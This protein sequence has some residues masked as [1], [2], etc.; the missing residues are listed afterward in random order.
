MSKSLLIHLSS[1]IYPLF[2]RGGLGDY[3]HSLTNALSDDFDNEIFIPYSVDFL[4]HNDVAPFISFANKTVIDFMGV[5]DEVVFFQYTHPDLKQKVHI[6]KSTNF[7]FDDITKDAY[8]INN[9]IVLYLHFAKAVLSQVKHL[10]RNKSRMLLVLHDWQSF[11]C[12]F[13]P[14][15]IIELDIKTVAIIHN[16]EYQGEM[17]PPELRHLR[18]EVSLEIN[19]YQYAEKPFSLTTL[20]LEKSDYVL[21]VSPN[22]AYEITNFKIPHPSL[23]EA[24]QRGSIQGFINGV[25]CQLWSSETDPYL[26]RNFTMEDLNVKNELKRDLLRKYFKSS[27]ES[28]I[29]FS[30]IS[31]FCSQKGIDL[32]FEDDLR[33]FHYLEETKS[34]M[35][36]YSVIDASIKNYVKEAIAKAR[37]ITNRFHFIDSYT[38]SGAHNLFA[39][40]D[41]LIMPSA[42]EP[43]GLSQLYAMQYGT[44]PIVS[45]RGGLRDTVEQG[46]TGFVMESYSLLAMLKSLDEAQNIFK[47]DKQSW[48][49]LIVNAKN[50][51]K[52]WE[53]R[54][55]PYVNFFN[56]AIADS[57]K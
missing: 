29:V 3:C 2:K 49:K 27:E 24:A 36:F 33:F 18:R 9:P 35:V 14:Q 21:T 4:S 17:S 7:I 39:S 47:N 30:F 31:R 28:A 20:M 5:Q 25:D 15:H 55:V 41:A 46:Q 50:L 1:E 13:Y 54:I 37:K 43:C 32:F 38:E 19:K 22:Y 56:E 42:Y 40:A 51:K 16:F 57:Q 44:L 12:F 10:Y 45:P 48:I 53:Q 11:G 34:Y 8:I 23:E 6:V 52:S 26:S